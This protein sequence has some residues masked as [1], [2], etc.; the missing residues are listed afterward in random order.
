[1]VQDLSKPRF[2][3][4]VCGLAFVSVFVPRGLSRSVTV[5][6]LSAPLVEYVESSCFGS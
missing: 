1:M 2:E 6:D 4:T 5:C 3:E